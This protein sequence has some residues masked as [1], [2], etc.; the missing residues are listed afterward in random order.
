[1]LLT[2]WCF[3]VNNLRM[4]YFI[5]YQ[6]EGPN[7]YFYFN[8]ILLLILMYFYFSRVF[9][10]GLLFVMRYFYIA[11]LGLIWIWILLPPPAL[12][13]TAQTLNSMNCYRLKTSDQEKGCEFVYWVADNNTTKGKV[14]VV[15]SQSSRCLV[16]KATCGLESA[17]TVFFFLIG[18][19]HR[20]ELES[21]N[22]IVL[23]MLNL[24]PWLITSITSNRPT[25]VGC[26]RDSLVWWRVCLK[27]KSNCSGRWHIYIYITL[28]FPYLELECIA[29]QPLR[30]RTINSIVLTTGFL[31][32][33]LVPLNQG[34]VGKQQTCCF[35]IGAALMCCFESETLC[36]LSLTTAND[37]AFFLF[38]F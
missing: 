28:P 26:P 13:D 21:L 15:A 35:R 27:A 3:S 19:K 12:C 7:Q 5:I 32:T 38:A 23:S 18:H 1:M 14:S 17:R 11:V 36:L 22:P 34:S 10:E 25:A 31:A 8:Y 37:T 29:W 4:S 24:N 30:C 6:S 33:V 16:S 20:T 2:H 9:H